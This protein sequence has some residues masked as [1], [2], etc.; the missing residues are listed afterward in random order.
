VCQ[1]KTDRVD[2]GPNTVIIE[3]CRDVPSRSQ[4]TVPVTTSSSRCL[5]L[6]WLRR[7]CPDGILIDL[8]VAY[9]DVLRD[10]GD[11][12]QATTSR[13]PVDLGFLRELPADGVQSL[14]LTAPIM[15]TT[16]GAIA[17]LAPG[18]HNL[19]LAWT[20]LDDAALD[21]CEPADRSDIPAEF[22]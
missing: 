12:W 8:S 3:L 6:H 19:Y 22:R 18:L 14:H 17:H 21:V 11:S 4:I 7:N 2:E 15:A 1:F 10:E 5:V 20:E 16:I 9:L 13:E